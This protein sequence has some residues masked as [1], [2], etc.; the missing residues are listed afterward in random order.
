MGIFRWENPGD[1]PGVGCGV[2]AHHTS[3]WL[4]GNVGGWYPGALKKGGS[5]SPGVMD[6]PWWPYYF[7]IWVVVLNIFDVHPYLGKMPMLTNIFSNGLKPSTR[8][9]LPHVVLIFTALP[10]FLQ[11][12]RPNHPK[13]VNSSNVLRSKNSKRLGESSQKVFRTLDIQ[14]HPEKVCWPPK[15][16]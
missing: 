16:A 15:H 7:H 4:R 5:T 12:E 6:D 8:Y 10:D 1:T 14:T 11:P 3:F 9:H 2:V 13:N